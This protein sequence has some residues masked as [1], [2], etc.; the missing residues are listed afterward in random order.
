MEQRIDSQPLEMQK[1]QY[2]KIVGKV[3][4]KPPILRN[5]TGA[6]IAGGL[7]AI[8]GQLFMNMYQSWGLNLQEA[9]AAM[10]STLIFLSALLTGIGVYDELAKYGGAGTI[11]PITGFAN[12]MV[13]PAMEYRSEGLVLGVGAR[14]FTIAGPVLVFGIVT[15]WIIGLLYYFF[16]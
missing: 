5:V 9:G 10:S 4:P 12:S 7:I 2:T 15:G 13:A 8:I 1:K 16:R 11:V 3:Y 6:F 14:L